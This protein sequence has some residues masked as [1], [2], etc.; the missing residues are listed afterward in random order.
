MIDLRRFGVLHID[1]DVAL[2]ATI[3]LTTGCRNPHPVRHFLLDELLIHHVHQ[4]FDD[5]GG[6]C[7][8]D[9]AMQP[10]LG[11]G[12]HRDRVASPTHGE[13]FRK[14]LFDKRLD[15]L[16]IV[17]HIFDVASG[18]ETEVAIGI[19]IR[20]VTKFADRIDVHLP[21]GAGA[22]CENGLAGL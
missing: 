14:Q 20:D 6:I 5:A 2:T 3:D 9:V 16:T 15:L 12:N 13:A 10:S 8:R 4:A 18:R 17:D 22:H 21:L 11:V 1:G 19:L 7:A